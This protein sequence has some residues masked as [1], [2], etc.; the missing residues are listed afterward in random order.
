MNDGKLT[1]QE[2]SILEKIADGSD[3]PSAKRAVIILMADGGNSVANIA[4]EVKLAPKTVQRWQKEFAQKRLGIF[5]EGLSPAEPVMTLV[6][7]TEAE[8]KAQTAGEPARAKKVKKEKKRGQGKA[9]IKYPVRDTI[10]LESTDSLAEAGRKVLE[11]H[12]GRMLT[13][14]PGTRLDSDM[15]AVH[16]MRVATRRMRAAFKLFNNEFSKKAI[17]RLGT[18]L[19]TTGR[20]LGEVRD[21]DVLVEK[22]QQYRQSLAESEQSDLQPLLELWLAQRKQARQE[23]LVYLDSKKYRRFKQELQEFVT[24]VDRGAKSISADE[25]KKYQLRYLIPCLLY[26]RFGD[27]QAYDEM[28]EEATLETLH[29]LRITFKQFRYALEY[30]A[31]ILGQ[32]SQK[33]IEE[34]KALQDHLGA[35][36]DARMAADILGDLV[37]EGDKKQSRL[38][39]DEQQNLLQLSAYLQALL[40]EQQ[41]LLETFP[42]TW[43]RFNSP[44]LRRNLALAIAV[45]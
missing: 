19:R 31:E 9:E 37:A 23:L 27:V 18:G 11:F 45:L 30:F 34:V 36:N 42:Q 33:V 32:E 7:E 5:P 13:H 21:L 16:D 26:T 6:A 39:L 40:E 17:K 24:T 22:L 44:E 10:G 25:P 15:E 28:L 1:D 8:E 12:F 3:E 29:E 14:E 4:K 43:G 38:S 41:R 2:K 35:L 20:I